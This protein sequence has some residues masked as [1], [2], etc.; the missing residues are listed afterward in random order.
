VWVVL[1]PDATIDVSAHLGELDAELGSLGC[2]R[3]TYFNSLPQEPLA[4][5][6][7]SVTEGLLEALHVPY[8]HADTFALNPQAAAV[9]LG[10]HDAIGTHIRWVLPM[11]TQD[12][13]ARIRATPEAD[14]DP[15]SQVACIWWISP[16]L[17]IAQELY[18]LI[19]AD[20]TPGSTPSESVFRYG[21]LSPTLEAPAG[22]PSPAEMAARAAKAVGQDQPVWEGCG[23]GLTRGAH[24][25][26]L[27]GRNEKGV[28]LL[29]E[30]VARMTGYQGLSYI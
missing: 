2:D 11:F 28:Q 19:Y 17:L 6:W 1:R 14:W 5:N 12:D 9:D 4:A 8:V 22:L 10:F 3:M 24:E 23:R 15:D 13:V 7:K 16:G 25:Y 20:L 21:W 29:H 26:A 27:I 30:I 18:G